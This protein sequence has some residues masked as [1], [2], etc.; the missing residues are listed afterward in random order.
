M[1]VVESES[2][3]VGVSKDNSVAVMLSYNFELV[4]VETVKSGMLV[5]LALACSGCNMII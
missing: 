5:L 4:S 2:E 1:T 3:G